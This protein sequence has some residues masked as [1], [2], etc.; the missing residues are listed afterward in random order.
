MEVTLRGVMPWARTG[1]RVRG[2][3]WVAASLMERGRDQLDPGGHSREG[4]GEGSL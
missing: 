4:G 2:R 3:G 1:G